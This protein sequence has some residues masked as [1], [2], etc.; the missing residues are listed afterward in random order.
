LEETA[1]VVYLSDYTGEI[2]GIDASGRVWVVSEGGDRISAWDGDS[3]TAYGAD[4][5]WT[6]ITDTW[7]WTAVGDPGQRYARGGE[8]D[9][10]GRL[11]FATSQDV[12]VFDGERWTVL[13][14]Q[15][16]GMEPSLDDDPELGFGV[17]IL[18]SGA[19]W[20]RE[21]DWGGPGP[22]GGRGVRWFD[23]STELTTGGSTWHGA[24]SPV[25]S[26]CATAIAEDGDG[27]VWL[28]ME[29]T[30]WRHDPAS[31]EWTKFA[32]PEPPIDWTRFG[33]VNYLTVD[34]SGDPWLMMVLCGASCYG[35]IV[36]YHVHDGAWTQIGKVVEFEVV[37]YSLVFTADASWLFWDRVV[38]RLKGDVPEP[39][40]DLYVQSVA[41]DTSG[42]VWFLAKHEDQD[43]LWALD[44]DAE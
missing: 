39:V 30:L 28:G 29:D 35:K 19:V 44:P 26:G 10:L 17:T 25:A 7:Y 41:V 43:W 16:M 8:S 27:R 34:P 15:D 21:C 37:P 24:D 6:P 33:F 3:W 1:W 20:V 4:A 2:A 9:A 14:L 31:G 22:I 42:R 40:A 11:W 13:T 5:G 38:Y 36:L 32:P 23:G 18:S 12:R